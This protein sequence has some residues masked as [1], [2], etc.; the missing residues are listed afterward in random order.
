MQLESL[1][2]ALSLANLVAILAN[3]FLVWKNVETTKSNA[4]IAKALADSTRRLKAIAQVAGEFRLS[5]PKE[6][7]R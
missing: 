2:M 3:C 5:L 6:E 4:A 7:K 1:L